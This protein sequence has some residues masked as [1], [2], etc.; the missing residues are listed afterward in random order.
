MIE[1]WDPYDVLM[2]NTNHIEQ[3]A[4][5]QHNHSK[6]I[7]EAISQQS[8]IMNAMVKLN[9]EFTDLKHRLTRLE[10]QYAIINPPTDDSTGS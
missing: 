4:Q 5:A 1:E 8:E 10:R 3:L 9:T 7:T 6:I 2:Q